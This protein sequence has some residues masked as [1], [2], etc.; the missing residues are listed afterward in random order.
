[1]NNLVYSRIRTAAA[2]TVPHNVVVTM[3]T[4]SRVG[5][6][7]KLGSV[8]FG[9]CPDGPFSTISSKSWVEFDDV[10]GV[11]ILGSKATMI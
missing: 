7:L 3:K 9:G 4:V 11:V 2:V 6:L 5:G 10:P 1:M 8:P